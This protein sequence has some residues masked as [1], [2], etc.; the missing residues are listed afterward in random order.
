[1]MWRDVSEKQ[2]SKKTDSSHQSGCTEHKERIGYCGGLEQCTTDLGKP[3][4]GDKKARASAGVS[5][6]PNLLDATRTWSSRAMEG[7]PA[8]ATIVSKTT[9]M[10]NSAT[11]SL[12]TGA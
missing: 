5:S 11:T 9:T 6:V 7:N 4:R 8:N 10:T 12:A 1:M 3:K 2:P